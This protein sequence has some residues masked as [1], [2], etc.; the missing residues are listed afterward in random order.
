M[1]P[2]DINKLVE[3]YIGT[4]DT[5]YLK[6]FS[7]SIHDRFYHHYC[8]VEVDVQAYRDQGLSTR[9]AFIAILKDLDARSQAKVIRGT[10]EMLPPPVQPSVEQDQKLIRVHNELLAVAAQL[11][12]DGLI[13][14]PA[15]AN[16]S[17]VVYSALQDA[18]TLLKT[19]GPIR[20]VDRAHTALHGYLNHLCATRRIE[21]P[22]D[23]A[24]TY[25]FKIVREQ[26]PEFSGPISHDDHAKRL[27]GS[28]AGAL[29]SLN[30]IRNRGSMAHP[31]E[32]LL[33]AAEAMLYI[34][35]SRAVLSYIETRI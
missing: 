2:R 21:L 9:K 25:V 22:A 10:F 18:E 29:D 6:H 15:P 19:N 5:G 27:F 8:D 23:S 17:E 12:S 31:N 11:E 7:Y 33:E 1:R 34:N 28:L 20:A 3:D 4:T 24:L 14:L 32:V 16:T 13:N 35:L 30:T 26:F